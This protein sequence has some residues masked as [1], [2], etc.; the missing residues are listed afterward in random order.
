[1]TYKIMTQCEIEQFKEK[2]DSFRVLK[3]MEDMEF[4]SFCQD[5]GKLLKSLSRGVT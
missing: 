5:N 3:D 4:E 2:S 1:M